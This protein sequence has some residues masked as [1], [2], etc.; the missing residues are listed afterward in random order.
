MIETL[1]LRPFGVTPR[2]L[3]TYYVTKFR[4]LGPGRAGGWGVRVARL[5]ETC[6]VIRYK[7]PGGGRP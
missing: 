5:G 6:N 1:A 2:K 7:F 4:D 3:V